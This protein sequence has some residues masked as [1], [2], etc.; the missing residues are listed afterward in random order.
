MIFGVKHKRLRTKENMISP[1]IERRFE[2]DIIKT[3]FPLTQYCILVVHLI[4]VS[5]PSHPLLPNK[6]DLVHGGFTDHLSVSACFMFNY[7]VQRC[8]IPHNLSSITHKRYFNI[9]Y[10]CFQN[11]N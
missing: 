8:S 10:N 7:I 4:Y 1:T 9:I 6:A 3:I 11:R 2:R 5:L